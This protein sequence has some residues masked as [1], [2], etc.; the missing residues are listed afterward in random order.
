M[1]T[2]ESALSPKYFQTAFLNEY[3]IEPQ[4][5]PVWAPEII[6]T[7]LI[8]QISQSDIYKKLTLRK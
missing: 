3:I 8:N 5:A 6:D 4:L 1:Y 7:D 2:I